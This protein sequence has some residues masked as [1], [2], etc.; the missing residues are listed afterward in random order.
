MPNLP[1]RV[2]FAPACGHPSLVRLLAWA[3]A[4]TVGGTLGGLFDLPG[5]SGGIGS[6]GKGGGG[7]AVR[8]AKPP[9]P[10]PIEPMPPLHPGRSNRPPSVPPTVA[11]TAQASNRTR[12]GWPQAGANGTRAG[13]FGMGKAPK[14]LVTAKGNLLRC[15]IREVA[16]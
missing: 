9:P 12:E 8:T 4:A 10:F 6:I 3:V 1:A 2:P 16:F 11:A 15:G 7:L 5:W 14:R 13:K